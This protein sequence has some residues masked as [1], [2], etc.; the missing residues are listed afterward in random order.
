M[1]VAAYRMAEEGWTADEAMKEMKSFGFTKSHHIICPSLAR[2]E[3]EFPDRLKNDP[4]FAEFR[5]KR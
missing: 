1:M 3:K 5:P 4:E 2:Y